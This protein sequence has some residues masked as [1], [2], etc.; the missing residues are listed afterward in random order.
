[1]SLAVPDIRFATVL[2]GNTANINYSKKMGRAHIRIVATPTPSTVATAYI[3]FDAP[4][5]AAPANGQ[6]TLDSLVPA[7]DADDIG[8]T[9]VGIYA[10]TDCRIEVVAYNSVQ[11]VVLR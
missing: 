6:F 5:A 1:M 8:F 2:A 10:V 11:G 9:I 3:A 4:P 7:Y